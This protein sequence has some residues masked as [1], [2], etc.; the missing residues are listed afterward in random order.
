MEKSRA[1]KLDTDGLSTLKYTKTNEKSLPLY[2]WVLAKL[3]P[4]PGKRKKTQW[5]MA[6]E[7]MWGGMQKVRGMFSFILFAVFE[8][9]YSTLYFI[10]K[11]VSLDT[12]NIKRKSLG[13]IFC[14]LLSSLRADLPPVLPRAPRLSP[15]VRMKT[16]R[17]RGITYTDLRIICEHLKCDRLFGFEPVP[18][19]E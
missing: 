9:I 16:R 1:N 6:K 19:V 14:E 7:G 11:P 12:K 10:R 15:P 5:E 8:I 17:A 4:G 13:E 2:T 3:P 18:S